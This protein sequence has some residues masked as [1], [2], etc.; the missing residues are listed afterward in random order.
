MIHCI[1]LSSSLACADDLVTLQ[2]FSFGEPT[3]Q[4]VS[5][6]LHDVLS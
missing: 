2:N 6:V 4:A 3:E 1:M 5:G